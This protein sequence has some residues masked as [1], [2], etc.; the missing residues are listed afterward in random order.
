MRLSATNIL[1]ELFGSHTTDSLDTALPIEETI[2]FL[3]YEDGVKSTE[4]FNAR[5]DRT[6]LRVCL[7]TGSYL[8]MSRSG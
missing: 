4:N 8:K 2:L 5:Y 1:K 3:C 6:S 7:D